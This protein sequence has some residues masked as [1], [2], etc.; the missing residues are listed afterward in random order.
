MLIELTE[1][2]EKI[3]TNFLSACNIGLNI[4]KLESLSG[5]VINRELLLS[6][7]TYKKV[8]PQRLEM[9]KMYSSSKCT[10]M[11]K[12]AIKTQVWPLLNLVRQVLLGV[13]Y[14]MVPRRISDGYTKD[15]KKRYKRIFE[16]S[17]VG[18]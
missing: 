6:D 3:I 15:G 7:E 11:H 4:D 2:R 8:S 1:E 13:G 14:E 9:S 16:I 5:K 10:S 17:R 18:A 12:N